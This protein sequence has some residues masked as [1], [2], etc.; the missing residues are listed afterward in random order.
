[1]VESPEETWAV[2]AVCAVTGATSEVYDCG[3]RQGAVDYLLRYTAGRVGALE[4]T[5]HAEPGL[6]EVGALLVRDGFRWTNPGRWPWMISF[7]PDANVKR[8]REIYAYVIAACEEHGVADVDL[9][10]FDVLSRDPVLWSVYREE[11]GV[12]FHG[13][14]QEH[15]VDPPLYVLPGA[16]AGGVDEELVHLPEVVTELLAGNHIA[17]HVAKLLRQP[18]DEHHLFIRVDAGGLPFP[19]YYP[20]TGVPNGVPATDPNAPEGLS[21]LWL[22]T[23]YGPTLLGWDRG[24]GWAAH[25]DF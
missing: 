23:G 7:D 4:V 12:R 14:P 21:H 25:S 20:L 5:S 1:V 19:Q 17:D 2:A 13:S 3:G 6:R 16:M 24:H 8:I 18:A 10:P 15:T 22:A 9:L 11:M